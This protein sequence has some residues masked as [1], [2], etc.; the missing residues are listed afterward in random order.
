MEMSISRV[1]WLTGELGMGVSVTLGGHLLGRESN[2]GGYAEVVANELNVTLTFIT[3][4]MRTPTITKA[5][6]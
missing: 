1:L 4:S 5:V 3:L 2:R 6:K